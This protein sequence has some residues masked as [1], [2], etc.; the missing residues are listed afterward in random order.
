MTKLDICLMLLNLLFWGG[1]LAFYF[2]VPIF[3]W[4]DNRIHYEPAVD[5]VRAWLSPARK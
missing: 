1:N 4:L 5:R 3:R 2:R